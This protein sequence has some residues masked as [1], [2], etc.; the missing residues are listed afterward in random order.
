MTIT[1][2]GK[3]RIRDLIKDDTTSMEVGG[4]G[5]APTSSDA[6]LGNDLLL[7]KT[8]TVTTSNKTLTFSSLWYSTEGDGETFREG[9]VFINDI[10]L[11]RYVYPDF[12]KD[13]NNE[14]TIIDIIKIL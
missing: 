13:T 10:L 8:P 5:T 2:N 9:G 14:L 6:D 4:D 1:D 7:T 11:D 12:S 3:N